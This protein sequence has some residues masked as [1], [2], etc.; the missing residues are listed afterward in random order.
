MR[1]LAKKFGILLYCP[2]S[3]SP[4]LSFI[5]PISVHVGLSGSGE[6]VRLHSDSSSSS[7]STLPLSNAIKS[8][9]SSSTSRSTTTTDFMAESVLKIQIAFTFQRHYRSGLTCWDLFFCLVLCFLGST[10]F[11]PNTIV[12]MRMLI[13]FREAQSVMASF[14]GWIQIQRREQITNKNKKIK[15]PKWSLSKASPGW[16][17]WDSSTCQQLLDPQLKRKKNINL[18]RVKGFFHKSNHSISTLFL[19]NQITYISSL[20]L[21]SSILSHSFP[22]FPRDQM[23]G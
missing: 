4:S 23:M 15:T 1:R 8:C 14:F 21:F 10:L 18:V 11:S 22:V 13:F 16:P 3:L 7:R 20:F 9:E 2:L 5:I 6:N 19:F 12:L 17:Q